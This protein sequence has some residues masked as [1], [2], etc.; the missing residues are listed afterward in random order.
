MSARAIIVLV[1]LTLAGC[2]HTA[3]A[4]ERATLEAVAT[5]HRDL[6][7]PETTPAE[8]W[9][10]EWQLTQALERAK[11]PLLAFVY[12]VGIAKAKGHPHQREAL[13]AIVRHQEA[14]QDD[15]IESG[16]VSKLSGGPDA[17]ALLGDEA[18]RV[19]W[20]RARTA[21]RKG[22]LTEAH[23]L[24]ARVPRSHR[25]FARAVILRAIILSDARWKPAPRTDEAIALLEELLSREVSPP[26]LRGHALLTLARLAHAQR[27]FAEAM[28]WY[29]QAAELR[30]PEAEERGWTALQLHDWPRALE[31]ARA[32]S[33]TSLEASL[34][35]ALALH[36]AGD[37]A[38][39]EA[40]IARIAAAPTSST[41]W[42]ETTP[43][44]A[45]ARVL[46]ASA[47]LLEEERAALRTARFQAAVR[48]MRS[49]EAEAAFVRQVEQWKGKPL[50]D[51]LA[52]YLESNAAVLRKYVGTSARI[53]LLRVQRTRAA[54]RSQAQVVSIEVALARRDVAT[55][56]ARLEQLAA[57][58]LPGPARTEVLFR[59]AALKQAQAEVLEGSAS[60]ALRAEVVALIQQ[61]LA[62]ATYPR[63]EEARA[64]LA[65]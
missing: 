64:F 24:A 11:L 56:A 52:G 17:P 22:E 26:A 33:G 48:S 13:Q 34:V 43:E 46:D 29:G 32:A 47:G 40:A 60:D 39:A 1:L 12:R 54:T 58:L 4:N 16:V 65:P 44:V 28:R 51:E 62:D 19:A 25:D 18:A 59:L 27:R 31:R 50:I 23:A 57:L 53:E 9:E 55:A 42:E 8:R 30:E 49:Y 38:A 3:P 14:T 21:F 20:V 5:L 2:A 35:E 41:N 36:Y 15:S 37:S 6:Q 63:L 61:V 10:R 45:L 7:A